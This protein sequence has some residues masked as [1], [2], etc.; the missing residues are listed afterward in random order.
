MSRG[1]GERID[2]LH[3]LDDRA[4]PTV[5]DDERQRLF[6]FRTNVN[7]MNV[8]AIDLGDELR[9][10]VQPYLAL[11]PVVLRRP[12]AGKR[13]SRREL[14]ALGCICYRFTFRPPCIVDAPSQFGEFRFWKIHFLKRTNRI[15]VRLLALF[16]CSGRLSHGVLLLSCFVFLICNAPTSWNEPGRRNGEPQRL[17]FLTSAEV[18]KAKNRGT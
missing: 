8:Q 5:R 1:I 2:D 17:P 6:M 7:E 11:A 15:L 14:H 18:W 3:L 9:Q 12:I 13:L 16:L 10:S 4:R